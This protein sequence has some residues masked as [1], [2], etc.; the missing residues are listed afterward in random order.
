MMDMSELDRDRFAAL[1]EEENSNADAQRLGIGTYAEKR[2]HRIL[3]R[4]YASD[5]AEFEVKVDS[6]IADIKDGEHIIEIQTGSLRP[7]LPKLRHYLEKTEYSVTVVHPIIADKTLVRINEE[8]GELMYRRRSGKHGKQSDALPELFWISELFGNSRLS[9][10]LPMI[11]T[12]EYRY[13][14]RIHYRKEGAYVSE[15]YPR[16]I[17]GETVL[18]DVRDC[19]IFL[20]CGKDSFES[21]EFSAFSKLKGRKLYSSLNFL[22][23]I[24]LLEKEAC[25]R[26]NLYKVKK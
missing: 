13:S 19:E 6:F 3:K 7:L 1:C 17:L 4:W 5:A 12:E 15:V 11:C 23:A 21:A 14:E 24:G 8:T 16:E 20:P 22:C 18:S 25:G 10:R 26:K 9:V 2:L